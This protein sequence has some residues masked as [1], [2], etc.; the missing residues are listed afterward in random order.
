VQYSVVIPSNHG[1]LL[2]DVFQWG[3]K[4]IDLIY[5]RHEIIDWLRESLQ[6]T[7]GKKVHNC[8]LFALVVIN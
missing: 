2:F 7:V 6:L 8:D 4:Y 5:S 1:L 3:N